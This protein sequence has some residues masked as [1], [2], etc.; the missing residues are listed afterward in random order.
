MTAIKANSVEGIC[1]FLHSYVCITII[2]KEY[3]TFCR[4]DTT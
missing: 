2:F 4:N 1:V 3:N